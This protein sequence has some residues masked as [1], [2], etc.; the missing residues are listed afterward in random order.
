MKTKK[1]IDDPDAVVD[2][3][4]EGMPAAHSRALVAA[5]GPRAGKIGIVVG[6]GSGHEPTFAGLVGRGLAACLDAAAAGAEVTKIMVATK[7]RASRLGDR[8]HG[9]VD[10]GAASAAVILRALA[11]SLRGL[12]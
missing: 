3:M 1:L 2:E 6:G 8:V 9:H 12:G 4:I 10:S 7:G 5:D 11:A